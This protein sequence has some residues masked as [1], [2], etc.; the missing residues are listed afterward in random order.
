MK[1]LIPIKCKGCG[2]I[3]YVEPYYS[4][5]VYCT[6]KCYFKNF[7][8]GENWTGGTL[9]GKGSRGKY[10]ESSV[11][12][13]SEAKV[14]KH[15]KNLDNFIDL[16]KL[17]YLVSLKYC[18]SIQLLF[19]YASKKDFGR[20]RLFKRYLEYYGLLE[21]FNNTPL[22]YEAIR[23][24]SPEEFLWLISLLKR[25]KSWIDLRSTF[26]LEKEEKN[27]K[28]SQRVL[29]YKYLLPLIKNLEIETEAF[30]KLG[31]KKYS[32]SG[33]LP[34]K[35][36]RKYLDEFSINYIEQF[37]IKSGI[38]I[39]KDEKIFQESF[40]R[41]DFIIENYLIVEINGDYW[42]GWEE[43]NGSDEWKK[44]HRKKD[45]LKHK[46]YEKLG[47]CY[48]VIWEHELYNEPKEKI[49][50]RILL[51]VNNARRN[52]RRII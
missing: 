11:R 18:K 37:K 29:S 28:L 19:R 9:R 22:Y 47:Y 17:K 48:I 45:E 24:A 30:D 39:C 12:A 49:L 23:K 4:K 31:N 52:F 14:L 7:P 40:Y 34:E 13:R 10:S 26:L 32:L 20:K 33:T 2:E 44:F 42:H 27:Y 21:D 36:F 50:N 25:C 15:I 16:D 41:A 8:K 43:S 5:R 35:I 1:K 6:Q 38:Y 3:F 46:C 51:G